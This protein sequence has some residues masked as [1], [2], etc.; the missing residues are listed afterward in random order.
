MMAKTDE[1]VR[2]RALRTAVIVVAMANLAYFGIE[3]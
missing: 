1:L 2:N 3:P